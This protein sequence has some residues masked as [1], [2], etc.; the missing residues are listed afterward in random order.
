[1]N[2]ARLLQ[3]QGRSPVLL[4][5][6]NYRDVK[7]SGGMASVPSF[8]DIGE[9]VSLANTYASSRIRTDGRTQASTDHKKRLC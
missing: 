6:E 3:T 4:M 1:M 7:T 9:I 8:C 2:G 5:R